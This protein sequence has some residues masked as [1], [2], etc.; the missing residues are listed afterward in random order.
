[1]ASRRESLSLQI[2]NLVREIKELESRSVDLSTKLAEYDRIL[3][4]KQ[5]IQT[6]RDN[7][8]KA[9]QSLQ[10]ERDINQ[11][12]VTTLERA[13]ASRSAKGSM[14]K[15]LILGG[16]LGLGAGLVL[17]FLVDRLDDRPNSFTDLH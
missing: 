14:I 12:T 8:Q 5:S 11:D 2:T 3:A 17:L 13:S 1:L 10:V 16:A 7:L 15:A 4:N 9:L 6:L